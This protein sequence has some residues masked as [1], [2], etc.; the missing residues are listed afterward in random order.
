MVKQQV[1]KIFKMPRFIL[2]IPYMYV[3]VCARTRLCKT[4]YVQ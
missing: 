4:M 2:Q 3:C 1:L